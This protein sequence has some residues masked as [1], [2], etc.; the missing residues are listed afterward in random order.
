VHGENQAGVQC[1]IETGFQAETKVRCMLKLAAPVAVAS[2]CGETVVQRQ[3]WQESR[4]IARRTARCALYECLS[5][6]FTE[7]D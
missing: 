5:R 7:S 6:L 4:A 3:W 1:T 2:R